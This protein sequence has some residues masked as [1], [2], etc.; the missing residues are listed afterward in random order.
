M[1]FNRFDLNIDKFSFIEKNSLNTD[2]GK[3]ILLERALL[4]YTFAKIAKIKTV[5]ETGTSNGFSSICFAKAMQDNGI[6]GEIHTIDMYGWGEKYSKQENANN[7]IE[8]NNAQDLVFQH[9]GNTIEVL[10]NLLK[11]L[12]NKVD[13]AHIDSEHDYETPKKE[14]ELIEPYLNKNAYVFFHDTEIKAVEKAVN[15]ILE[16]RK[17]MYEKIFIPVCNG[18]TVLRKIL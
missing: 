14:F 4:L 3:N 12:K 16:K 13:F 15:D 18:M 5:V 17:N 7:S 6:K 8:L 10:P 1:N 11:Q 2:E 9:I